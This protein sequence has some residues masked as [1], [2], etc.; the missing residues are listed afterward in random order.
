MWRTS[1]TEKEILKNLSNSNELI[2][3]DTETSGR[4][5]QKDRI[6]QISAIK[7]TVEDRKW[8]TSK[9]HEV[10]K[11]NLYI[12]PFFAI[13]EL[14]EN[15]TGITNEFLEDKPEEEEVFSDI[16]SFFGDSPLIA[17]YNSKFDTAFLYNLY[18][19]NGK[20]LKNAIIE[21]GKFKRLK[22]E[23]DVLKVARDLVDPKEVENFK[24][25]TIVSYYGLD[26]GVSFHSAD[27]DTRVTAKLLEIFLT[28]Y[29]ERENSRN[30]NKEKLKVKFVSAMYWNK[31][32]HKLERIY[33]NTNGPKI[34]YDIFKKAWNIKDGDIDEIDME[35]LRT[36]IFSHYN[37]VDEEQFVKKMKKS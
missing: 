32:G 11:L 4:S 23:I 30:E 25:K 28:E 8:T 37:I 12:K 20:E 7:Y 9:F 33:V 21:D 15:L 26:N 19:R 14:I 35:D 17:A 36:Q 10:S 24:L 31:F 16:Y 1:A 3:F 6:I 2:V 13:E 18:K 27:E 34:Y 22:D 5:P 29:N